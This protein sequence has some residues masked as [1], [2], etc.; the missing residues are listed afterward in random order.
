MRIGYRD[1]V[2]HNDEISCTGCKPDNWCR[3]HV[4]DC[5]K[6]KGI[7]TCAECSEYPCLKMKE[8]FEITA[9]FE[10]MCRKVCTED[11]YRQLERAFFRKEQNLS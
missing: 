9:S 5:C 3:Y 8:C 6:E 2:V 10:P 4:V 7:R 1:Q 11:E